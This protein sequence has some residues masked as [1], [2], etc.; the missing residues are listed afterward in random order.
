MIEYGNEISA[1]EYNS[2]RKSVGWKE[3]RRHAEVWII[4]CWWSLP[5]GTEKLS[6]Q[7]G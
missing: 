5:A 4:P 3:L 1:D 7:R 6:V 2:L